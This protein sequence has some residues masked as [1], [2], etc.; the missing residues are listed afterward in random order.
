MTTS[1]QIV[2]RSP[3]FASFQKYLVSETSVGNISRQEAVSMIPPLFMGVKPGMTV[4][5]MCAAPG[6]KTVQLIEMIHDGEEA[7]MKRV[8]RDTAE[9]EARDTISNGSSTGPDGDMSDAGRA[10]GL[11]IANDMDY[12]RAHMLIHQVKRLSSPNLIVTNHDATMYPS[13]KLPS[14]SN[15]SQNRY[16]KYDRILADV[17]CSGD[18]TA[19]KNINVWKDWNS[20][21]SLGL[22]ATQVRI[23]VRA[24]QL[25]KVKGQVVYSTCS[26]N[27]LENEAVIATAIERCG[28][29]SKV[30]VIDCAQMLPDL[31]RKQG[32]KDWGVM[33]KKGRIWK[34]WSDVEQAQTEE[35]SEGLARLTEGMFP[36]S[37]EDART[38]LEKCMRVYP[39]LQD[40]G[41]FFITVLQKM[42]EIRAKPESE[43]KKTQSKPPLMSVVDEIAAKPV[44]GTN[45]TD[46]IDALDDILPPQQNGE[47]DM[48]ST[49]A[50]QNQELA[51]EEPVTGEKR[52]VEM[53]LDALQATKRLKTREPGDAVEDPTRPGLADR[54]VH[55][56][57]PPGAELNLTR[58]EMEAAPEPVPAPSTQ[59][60]SKPRPNGSFEEPFKYL[61][62][63][64]PELQLI[65][66]FYHL[67]PKFPL[68]RFMVRNAEGKPV[69]TIY[70]TSA[71]ARGILTGN[72]GSGLKFVHCG[73][74]MF[75]KQD[76]Q[77]PEVCRWRIQS[78]GM[79]LLESYVGPQR[80]VK[81][82]SRAT[83]RKLL[84]EMFP[85]VENEGW[86]DLGEIGE[87]VRDASQGCYVLEI[88]PREGEDGFRYLSPFSLTQ[89]L[90]LS[91]A[92]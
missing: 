83:L 17:P 72:E 64:H 44:D 60:Q 65:Q 19:R 7:R 52:S 78:E 70:Y 59:P 50:R 3:P 62:S 51:P 6:S 66:E 8:V 24:L 57:P 79:P 40:T 4:L 34:S 23:L 10:T 47:E 22:F 86:R 46:K 5:D 89:M 49:A 36:P 31:K 84:I 26:M 29:P 39:H 55:W 81:L 9:V 54:Q 18:G 48:Q 77:S 53:K 37:D 74:K 87:R 82:W 1:K 80:V 91:Q 15:K 28:G 71:L 38:S 92:C 41:G 67:S 12:K 58:P 43:T 30:D 45:M 27:P 32:M 20:G 75:V 69:K 42:T 25:L 14:E 76:V 56:P 2:R 88:E 61:S 33:D 21:N 90:S 13:I 35:G 68:D 11:L 73:I 85:K 16:L 63:D